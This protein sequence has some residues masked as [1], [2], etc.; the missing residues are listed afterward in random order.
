MRLIQIYQSLPLIDCDSNQRA[1]AAS[2]FLGFG[3]GDVFENNKFA[4]TQ[5]L[6]L[7]I[8]RNQSKLWTTVQAVLPFYK[9]CVSGNTITAVTE[10]CDTV[11]PAH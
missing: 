5:F 1:T 2:C 8:R 11:R 4:F 9:Y 3:E 7:N 10:H 6:F